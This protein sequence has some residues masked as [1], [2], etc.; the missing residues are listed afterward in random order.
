MREVMLSTS[1]SRKYVAASSTSM[2]IQLVDQKTVHSPS[3]STTSNQW[4]TSVSARNGP[5]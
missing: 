1:T 4:P 5:E 3:S 2:P